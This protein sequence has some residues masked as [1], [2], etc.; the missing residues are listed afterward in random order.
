MEKK[1]LVPLDGSMLAECALS[2]VKDFVKAGIAGE[3]T[4]LSVIKFD[5]P[6]A[7]VAYDRTFDFAAAR[8][9][10]FAESRKYLAQVTSLL[11]AEGISVKAEAIEANNIAHAVTDYARTHGM[12]MIVIATHGYTGMKKMLLGSVA[13][14]I[15][16]QSSVPVH[17][18][19]PEACRP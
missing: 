3:V 13:F 11:A 14:G 16:S 7:E 8:K 1:I 2:P 18:I 4:L 17:L 9:E 10:L 6:W 12:D 15:L 5:I 19:R